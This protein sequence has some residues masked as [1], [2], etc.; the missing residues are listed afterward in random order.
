MNRNMHRSTCRLTREQQVHITTRDNALAGDE[1]QAISLSLP[2]PSSP[3]LSLYFSL[4]LE[5][6]MLSLVRFK[7][8]SDLISFGGR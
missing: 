5:H 3:S 4:S 6:A 1:N 2:P 7:S 8:E